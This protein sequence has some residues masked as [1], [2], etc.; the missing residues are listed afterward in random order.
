MENYKEILDV[1]ALCDK[2][3]AKNLDEGTDSEAE[4]LRQKWDSHR[5]KPHYGFDLYRAPSSWFKIIDDF[6]GQIKKVDPDFKIQQI[7]TKFGG[8]R[9]YVSFSS[10]V[11]DDP[12]LSSY[13]RMQ[14]EIL[15]R[16]LFHESLIY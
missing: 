1:R 3:D 16:E 11:R 15:E 5:D 6:L 7:K 12:K 10:V 2:H 8:V 9:F 14:I 4:S 13:I